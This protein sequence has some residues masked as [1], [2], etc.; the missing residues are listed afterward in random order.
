MHALIH[1]YAD[2]TI[3]DVTTM[4]HTIGHVVYIVCTCSSSNVFVYYCPPSC[5]FVLCMS[6]TRRFIFRR[7]REREREGGREGGREGRGGE[8]RGGVCTQQLSH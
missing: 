8:G 4:Y 6:N 7:E 3:L 5:I 1:H 2:C